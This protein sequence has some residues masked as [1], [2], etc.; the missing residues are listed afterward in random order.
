MQLPSGY[1]PYSYVLF[2]S[3]LSTNFKD[4][5]NLDKENATLR[6]KAQDRWYV[7]DPN[8]QGDLDQVRDRALLKE[9]EEVKESSQRKIKVFR[10]EA[11]RAGFKACWQT[12]DYATIVKVATKLPEAV[13]QEDEKLLMYVDNAQ[14][15]LGDDA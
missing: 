10:T 5:R 1:G 3:Y 11:I 12:N 6:E 8:K 7:P 9:F 13:L 4:L 2:H 14:T 15:R